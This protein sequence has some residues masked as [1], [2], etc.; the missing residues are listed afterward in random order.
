[1]TW[2]GLSVALEESKDVVMV[3]ETDVYP[4]SCI[5]IHSSE[6][7]TFL[8]PREE[9]LIDFLVEMWD[10]K[11]DVWRHRIKTGDKPSTEIVNPWINFIGCTTP[12]WM[13]GNFPT[14]MIEGGLTSRCVFLWGNEKRKLVAYPSDSI[15]RSWYMEHKKKL[16]HDLSLFSQF[17]GEFR[18][19]PEAREWGTA[20]Y[21]AHWK[22]RPATLLSERY[23]GYLSRK[24]T[25][26]HKLAMVLAVARTQKLVIDTE[27]LQAAEHMIT[28]SERDLTAVFKAIGMTSGARVRFDVHNYIL[29][30]SVALQ[31]DL[32]RDMLSFADKRDIEEALAGLI[33]AGQAKE[34]VVDGHLA[35]VLTPEGKESGVSLIA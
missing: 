4:M 13:R 14:Y 33:K 17:F 25:H 31:R 18:I 12:S 22:G 24:Q 19:T 26:I 9:G 30:H 10:G 2:Q 27:I 35:Y 28:S 32:F 23:G 21:E 3:N 16:V 6:L 34:V 15:D 20:W 5:T 1:M 11:K 8:K 7:G 29:H